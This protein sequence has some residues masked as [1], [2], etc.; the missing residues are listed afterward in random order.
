MPTIAPFAGFGEPTFDFLSGLANNNDRDWFDANRDGYKQHFVGPA[1]SFVVAIGE[2]MQAT[3]PGLRAEPKVNGSIF[4]INRDTRFSA[5]KTPY[6]T[7]MDMMWHVGLGRSRE[8]PGLYFRM[9]PHTLMLGAGMHMFD[10]DTLAAYREAVAGS[11][12]DELTRILAPLGDYEIGGQHYKKLPKGLAADHPRAELLKH[13][14][15]YAGVQFGALPSESGS[16][17]FVD[18]CADYFEPLAPLLQWI[19]GVVTAARNKC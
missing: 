10:K 6:K 7:H 17:A 18:F 2:R 9:Y 3:I 1:Q 4:R 13:N 11:K 15:L 19:A 8:L 16:A 12:G 14:A 5:D